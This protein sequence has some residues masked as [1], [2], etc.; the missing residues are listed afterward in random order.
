MHHLKQFILITLIIAGAV[1]LVTSFAQIPFGNGNFWDYRGQLGGVFFLLSISFFP[2]LTLLFSSVPFGGLIWWLGFLFVPRILVAS[3]ATVTYWH[4]NPILVIISW[5]VALG[6]ESS[7]KILITTRR[8]R[9]FIY[10]YYKKGHSSS[11]EDSNTI[12]T[13]FRRL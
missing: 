6:G 4:Q 3:L 9:P 5:F 2:R 12:E 7:E 8:K 13:P 11:I 1:A 10:R